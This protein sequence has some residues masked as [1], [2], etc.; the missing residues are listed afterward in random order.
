MT[1]KD[2]WALSMCITLALGIF[3][4]TGCETGAEE[5]VPDLP[6]IDVSGGPAFPL[7]AHLESIEIASGTLGF[8]QV[9]DAGEKLFHIPFNGLDG[10]GV[11]RLP[12]GTTIPRF[13]VA[14]PGGGARGMISSQSCGECHNM[15]SAASA[16]LASTNRVGDPDADGL[17]PF[18]TRS[19]T[20][21]F[22]DAI[23]QLLAQEITEELHSIR[24][25]AATEAAQN[26]GTRVQRQLVSKGIDFGTIVGTADAAGEVSFDLTAIQ[27]VDPDLVVRPIGWKGDGAT[28]RV[29][30]VG[31]SA[32]L[33]GML[34]EELVWFPPPE[35]PVDPD[36]DGD[37]VTRELSVGDVTAI[38]IYTAAQEVPQSLE[39]LAELGMVAAPDEGT[40]AKI[41]RGRAVFEEV[42]CAA[43]HM[44]ELRLENT[45][46]E[47]P[48]L[49]GNGNF[50]NQRLAEKDPGYDPR[51][52]VR[53]DIL[54]D[55]QP[56]RAEAHREGGA[57]V[58]LYGDLKRH[59]MGR[60]LADP[61]G[62]QPSFTANFD[63]LMIDGALVLIPA[64]VFLTPELWGVGNTGPWL[65][66]GRAGSLEE[67]ILLHGEDDPPALEDPGRSEAQESR[68]AFAA[69]P[70]EDRRALVTFLHS[71]RTFSPEDD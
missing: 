18:N 59:R 22:G 69:L 46:F 15:P 67:A 58:R 33:M 42:G 41:G 16:G 26:P 52:P 68:D 66:D 21:L 28:V 56:P 47:E 62:P 44:P 23:V 48:T 71:L 39:R 1:A 38:T 2:G 12:D 30:V 54:T 8:E 27:G 34:A 19:T 29:P 17:P 13:S 64:T 49:R 4:V 35:R 24:E 20:S 55:S 11:S 70:A 25:D 36:P 6:T 65:H 45:V 61:A 53:F 63:P 40:L 32:G 3:T 31:A 14:P 50:Y 43:C 9:F 7:Q 60:H 10:V 5:A 37:G 57:I 51:R